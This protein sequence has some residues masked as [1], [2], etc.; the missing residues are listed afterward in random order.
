M[1]LVQYHVQWNQLEEVSKHIYIF[2]SSL[3]SSEEEKETRI[4]ELNDIRGI[5]DGTNSKVGS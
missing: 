4:G 2:V 1:V 5:E 3:S